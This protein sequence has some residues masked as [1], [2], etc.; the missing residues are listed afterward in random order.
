MIPTR[1]TAIIALC[2]AL[3]TPLVVA[4]ESLDRGHR[5]LLEKGLQI[6]A[7]TSPYLPYNSP[8]DDAYWAT[9][10]ASGFTTP[11]ICLTGMEKMP[12][13]PDKIVFQKH[14]GRQWAFQSRGN[15]AVPKALMPTLVSIQYLDEQDIRVPAILADTAAQLAKYRAA[16]PEVISYMNFGAV[17]SDALRTYMSTGQ[18]DMVCFD[19]YTFQNNADLYPVR[20]LYTSLAKYRALALGGHDG[21]GNRPIPFGMYVQAYIRGP[22]DRIQSESEVNLNH[23]AAWAFGYTMTIAFVY[24][25]AQMDPH[26]STV[27]FASNPDNSTDYSRPTAKNREFAAVNQEG[28]KLGPTLVR[29]L[30][31]DVRMLPGENLSLPSRVSLWNSS[32]GHDQWCMT[33]ISASNLGTMNHGKKG[34]VIIGY[35]KPL[36]ES[37]DGDDYKDQTYFMIV[38]A[39]TDTK[40]SGAACRQRITID[41]DFGKSGINSLQRLDRRTGDVIV[42]DGLQ[43]LGGSKYRYVLELDG[44]KG[45]LFKY[46]TGAP[47]ISFP[48]LKR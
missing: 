44:G 3:W 12:V 43:R 31:T 11:Y 17:S 45:D 39:L 48:N 46:N 18:P 34:D 40:G 1:T 5:I 21:T 22:G 37:F 4:Q 47:F 20:E 32:A 42:I 29:L 19:H 24:D 41:F 25:R 38:N 36:L 10:D 23:F 16:Y 14:K 28:Q 27:L 26:L 33:S 8:P 30:S 15:W 2:L 6:Q 7:V 13:I 9:L 35:F